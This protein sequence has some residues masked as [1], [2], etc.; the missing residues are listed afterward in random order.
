MLYDTLMEHQGLEQVMVALNQYGFG[1]QLS[2]RMYQTYKDDTLD[3]IQK[4]PYKLVED[5]EGI[6]FGRADELGYQL[7][8]TGNHPERI[9]A[10]CLYSLENESMQNGHVY[11][12]VEDL[13]VQVKNLLED[14]QRDQIEFTD[15]STEI[16]KLEEEGKI[17]GEEK[18]VYMPSLYFA[19][20]GLVTSINKILEQTEYN[21][22]FPESEFLLALGNLEER[23]NVQY[24]P[25]QGK[26]FKLP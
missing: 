2:M 24:A 23:L 18:R 12:H 15:I 7:G 5:I 9:K 11:V 19:E 26:R 13:L 21:E 10:A 3:I 16:V 25:T 6:G 1:P 4:N 17:I 14:N 22:Q 8:I 20:R